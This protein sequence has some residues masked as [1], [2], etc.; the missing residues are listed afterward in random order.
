MRALVCFLFFV[1]AMVAQGQ[2][3]S[4][5]RDSLTVLQERFQKDYELQTVKAR[6]YAQ[7]KNI[8]LSYRN[9]NG[10]LVSLEGIE[11]DGVTPRYITIDNAGAAVTTGV[12]KLRNDGG[13][14]LNLEGEGIVAGVWDEGIVLTDHVEFDQRIVQTQGSVL[15]DHATHVSGTIV[16]LG[17]N[18]NAKGMA[19][20]AKVTSWD[21]NNALSEM[22]SLVAPDQT[23]LLFSNHSWGT[24]TGWAF[25]NGSWSWYGNAS[26]S[27]Q[28]DYRFG[29]YSSST[30]SW[31]ELAFNAPYFTIC[32]SAGNDRNN[33][34]SGNYPPDC[35]M[36][37]G[38]DCLG[39]VA[40]A[41]NIITVGAV[42][43]LQNYTGPASVQMSSFSS[44]GPTDDGRI[45]PDLVGAGVNIYST[46]TANQTA[47]G[48]LSGTSMASPNV[49]GSLVL[50]QELYMKTNAKYM[51]AS[52]LKALAIHTTK[53]AGTD[54]GPDYKFGWGLLDVE[55]SA[56]VILLEDN[57]NIIIA[58]EVLQNNQVY[59]VELTPI[60]NTKIT[61]T[62]VWTDPA[63]NPVSPSLDPTDLM[64]VNDLDIRIV[65]S[66][67]GIQY[68]WILNPETPNQQA[69]K[70]DNFRDNVEKIEFPDPQDRPYKLVVGHKNQLKNGQQAFSL[71]LTYTSTGDPSIAYY[72]I[73]GSGSWND[74][75]HWSLTSGG[76]SAG[77]VPT[78]ADRIFF[79]ENSFSASAN[80]VSFTGDAACASLVW[81]ANEN[82]N[83]LLNNNTLL[84]N[85]NLT[86]TSPNVTTTG[87]GK[88]SFSG[89]KNENNTIFFTR[90]EFNGIDFEFDG[91]SVFTVSGLKSANAIVL[92]SGDLKI[93]GQ[94]IRLKNLS[95]INLGAQKTLNLNSTKLTN[96]EQLAIDQNNLTFTA[97][98]I[99]VTSA[100]VAHI[101]LEN[102]NFT[103]SIILPVNSD[104]EF[105]GNDNQIGFVRVGGVLDILGDNNFIGSIQLVVGT[106]LGIASGMSL[107][108]S[109]STTI[110][111]NQSS[112]VKINA[113]G[114]GN[115]IL[116]FTG[117]YKL[118]F[119]YLEVSNV[120]IQG[121][122][123]IN[124]GL[125]SEVESSQNWLKRSCED[126]V[127]AD[128]SYQYGC[129]FSRTEFKSEAT[130]NI[131][132]WL[133]DFGDE[134]SENDFS[135][136]EIPGY[137]YENAGTYTVSLTVSDGVDTESVSK[138]IVIT[139]ND[140]PSNRI[141]LS[142][143]K[144]YSFNTASSY[145]WY[146]D[147]EPISGATSRDYSFND[148][149]GVYF[150]VT[151][152]AGCN[153][154]SEIYSK[155]VTGSEPDI[156]KEG[157]SIYPNPT[158]EFIHVTIPIDVK[159]YKIGIYDLL[160]NRIDSKEFFN[161][162]DSISVKHIQNGIYMV[163]IVV[164]GVHVVRKVIKR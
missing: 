108:L 49:T 163:H 52:T 6:A 148:Q 92:K 36:G 67:S 84:I 85:G 114:S 56:K 22:A 3:V 31:D 69:A 65:D 72:W 146:K 47:Y 97:E 51:R 37:S 11:D 156:L 88:I 106:N 93:E 116:L 13:L 161:K 10:Y 12:V 158:N 25:N 151:K 117:H 129:A 82:T 149:A 50:L 58:E 100:L 145:Q 53:E 124:A 101:H 155:I 127:F 103:G 16:A 30:K 137:V 159:S 70:G 4:L 157:I 2:D 78:G 17:V 90:N 76:S 111:S 5:K 38:F 59:E 136:N 105:L 81:F 62:I 63:G 60:A 39:D 33:T 98:G 126:I 29:F 28:E 130:G 34:G 131:T 153:R 77:V 112:P 20:K 1:S 61:A 128:F 18:A 141:V 42:S 83:L 102:I 121:N 147:G 134:N 23:S 140:L 113:I 40:T 75:A 15:S 32:K 44:W 164:N 104:V 110:L 66:G 9:T 107:Q 142:G 125:H 54:P 99:E 35:D 68:P 57:T 132:S 48:S 144:L 115:A 152:N 86:V 8:P 80:T 26:I 71:I 150:V 143:G 109:E 45:K 27:D 41:K 74:P 55:A 133:W 96:V 135:D 21:W 94:E 89:T 120:D 14:G 138:Q 7:Q 139:E 160:G 79:D 46:I 118:C 122:A 162:E 123:T 19:P 64:L 24:I 95:A 119:D 154:V 87:S 91:Q 73:G 43:K